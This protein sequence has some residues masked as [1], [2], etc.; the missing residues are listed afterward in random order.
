MKFVEIAYD[1]LG[2]LWPVIETLASKVCEKNR[3][4]LFEVVDILWPDTTPWLEAEAYA[5]AARAVASRVLGIESIYLSLVDRNG[6]G[7]QYL[8]AAE[9]TREVTREEKAILGYIGMNASL[10]ATGKM[11]VNEHDPDFIAARNDLLGGDVV[12]SPAEI[13]RAKHVMARIQV[14]L[15]QHWDTIETLATLLL[16]EYCVLD[17]EISYVLDGGDVEQWARI[18]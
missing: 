10:R 1:K 2:A 15:S 12:H 18:Y 17:E 3:L 6:G 5:L 13:A 4:T 11:V 7:S 14:I 16:R 8:C 9:H